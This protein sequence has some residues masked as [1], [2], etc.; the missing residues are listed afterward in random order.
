V[1]SEPLT[2]VSDGLDQTALEVSREISPDDGMYAYGPELYFPAGQTALRY[3]RLAR[4]AARADSVDG[5]DRIL[6]FAC[7]GGRVMR[8]LRAAYPDASITG[9]ELLESLV[10]FCERNFGATGVVS[11]PNPAEIELD[12]E[13]DVIWSGSLLTHVKKSLWIEFFDVMASRLAPGGVLVFTVYGPHMAAGIR[14][15]QHFLD[16]SEQQA[17]ETVRE[18]EET[19]FGFRAADQRHEEGFGDCIVSPAWACAQ[20][21]ETAPDLELALYTQRCWLDQDVI[22][23][24]RPASG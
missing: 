15:G 23:V 6:D 14:A 24:T 5:V 20:I 4:L 7:G 17:K 11:K 2:T 3:I 22:A 19:G 16:L 18:F 10:R 9:V 8:F 1:A 12:G 13:F 21:A